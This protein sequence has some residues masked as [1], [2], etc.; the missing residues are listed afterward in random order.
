MARYAKS[1]P[2]TPEELSREWLSD[3]LGHAIERLDRSDLGEGV[4][5]MG[6]VLKLEYTGAGQSG[7][8]VA[9]LPKKANRVMGELL[10]VYERE[11]MFFRT[12]AQSMPV[13][14][15]KLIFS[16]FDTD[17]GSENQREILAKI[18]RLPL[19]M[20]KLVSGLG[21][22]IAASKKRRYCL[23]IEYLNDMVPGDQL[24]GLDSA[25]CAQVL[26]AIAPMHAAHWND[27]SLDQHF[28]LLPLNIDT[29]LRFG[30]FK[31]HV[32]AFAESAPAGLADKLAWL[33][34]NGEML[35]HT[36]AEQAPHTLLHNDLRLDNVVF[37]GQD[38]AFI[39]WQLVRSGPA[40][41]DVAYFLS[42]A[43]DAQADQSQ[44][45]E[46]LQ[47]YCD[48]LGQPDYSFSAMRRDYERALYLILANLSGVDVVQLGD[49]RGR[50]VMDAWFT[51][52]AA[53]LDGIAYPV[54]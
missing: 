19:F 26:K 34:A 35:M 51:R 33:K 14:V 6:D 40:A 39:D 49:G 37:D 29:R 44:V 5:F 28:W 8:L 43:L 46:L 10:G 45:D 12:F 1:L 54:I 21:N 11:I 31:Q 27:V 17:K 13:R 47:L 53:R 50:A 38:C 48:E 24:A 25:G 9:K 20:S 3:V 41:Y 23:L 18:D 15:P 7:A 30:M 36:F 42:S 2:E 16:A 32:D 4:G 22:Y 52:L